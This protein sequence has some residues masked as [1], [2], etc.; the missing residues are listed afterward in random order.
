MICESIHLPIKKYGE[1]IKIH[2][3]S[4]L[5]YGHKACDARQLSLDLANL[6]GDY[7]LGLGDWLDSI[8]TSDLK[9]YQKSSDATKGDAILDE[10]VDNLTALFL[11]HKDRI[12]GIAEGNH[13]AHILRLCG[14]N[15]AKRIAANLGARFLGYSGLLALRLRG[16][17]GGGRTVVIRYHHGFGGGSRTQGADLTKFSRDMKYF[18]ADCYLYGHVHKKQADRIPRL[19]ICGNKLIAKPRLLG[20]A[21]T[22]LKTYTDHEASTYSERA[23]Y[24][25]TE[26]GH[27]TLNIRPVRT[28]VKMWIDT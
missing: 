28:W 24:P 9:R 22:Y 12:L 14:T 11:P 23:G 4:D 20:I 15:P 7:I 10:Q 21:G 26:I 17:H 25:P 1:T 13:E 2:V 5:H 27:I 6:N 19:G 8:V 16:D 3:L 18:E